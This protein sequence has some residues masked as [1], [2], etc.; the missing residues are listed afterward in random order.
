M[1]HRKVAAKGGKQCE[2]GCSTTMHSKGAETYPDLTKGVCLKVT[3][4]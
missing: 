2:H 1:P 3:L 4:V